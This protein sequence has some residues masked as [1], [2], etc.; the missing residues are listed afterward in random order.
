[1]H[2][3]EYR[4]KYSKILTL[5]PLGGK[6]CRYYFSY[7]LFTSVFFNCS[8]TNMFIIGGSNI[9]KQN[10]SLSCFLQDAACVDHRRWESSDYSD[11]SV[12]VLSRTKCLN[13]LHIVGMNMCDCVCFLSFLFSF[14]LPRQVC[15][16]SSPLLLAWCY[17]YL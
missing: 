15:L 10:R 6:I 13:D 11:H 14:F 7:S 4:K 17:K 9:Y 3:L 16:N 8:S 12:H 2:F 1:M 5:L